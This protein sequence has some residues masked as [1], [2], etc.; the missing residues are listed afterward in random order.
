M[1]G[2]REYVNIPGNKMHELPPLLVRRASGAPQVDL[3]SAILEA[4]EMLP[5]VDVEQTLL[6]RRKMDLALTLAERTSPTN[7]SSSC[8]AGSV[9]PSYAVQPFSCTAQ[10]LPPNTTYYFA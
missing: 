2:D 8:S 9:A 1:R 5:A 7:L 10:G 6:E 3:A 4:E